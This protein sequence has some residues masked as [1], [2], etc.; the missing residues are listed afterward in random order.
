MSVFENKEQEDNFNNGVEKVATIAAKAEVEK[1]EIPSVEGLA[2]QESVESVEKL[3]KANNEAIEKMSMDSQEKGGSAKVET[4]KSFLANPENRV[5]GEDN[6]VLATYKINEDMLNKAT[7][8]FATA[9][10]GD[11]SSD[12]GGY[13]SVQE[14]GNTLISS[15]IPNVSTTN[16]NYDFVRINFINGAAAVAGGASPG[17]DT[18]PRFVEVTRQVKR[19]KAIMPVTR[20]LYE[21]HEGFASL[22]AVE[23]PLLVTDLLQAQILTGAGTGNNLSG[24]NTDGSTFGTPTALADSVNNATNYD[25]A[26]AAIVA[27]R[28]RKYSP[29]AIILNWGDIYG[30]ESL[31]ATTGQYLDATFRDGALFAIAGVPVVGSSDQTLGQLTVLDATRSVRLVNREGLEVTISTENNDNFENDVYSLKVTGRWAVAVTHPNGIINDTFA[32]IRTHIETP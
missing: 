13:V 31:K 28:I 5:K 32:A 23:V 8:T 30:I 18:E 19:L 12:F 26:R 7:A 24:I 20:E 25:A 27:L 22:A 11:T 16:Q 15:I 3:A 29:T 4:L 9:A 21:D 14:S 2:K 17:T 6:S 1:L 10:T